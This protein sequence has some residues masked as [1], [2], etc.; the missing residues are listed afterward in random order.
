MVGGGPNITRT[1]LHGSL[2]WVDPVLEL[3]AKRTGL[4]LNAVFR[5]LGDAY[6]RTAYLFE[7][8]G[9][10]A[11]RDTSLDHLTGEVDGA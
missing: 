2:E 7:A 1:E 9:H 3:A 6:I 11:I 8:E 5:R 10:D 4:H